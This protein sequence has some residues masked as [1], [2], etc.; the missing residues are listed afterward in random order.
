MRLHS[1]STVRWPSAG[2]VTETLQATRAG[3]GPD[4]LQW[5]TDPSTGKVTMTGPD[6]APEVL[7]IRVTS[8]EVARPGSTYVVDVAGLTV[9]QV[10]GTLS[11]SGQ[12]PERADLTFDYRTPGRGR[13]VASA[14]LVPPYGLTS[15]SDVDEL[16]WEVSAADGRSATA[17][18]DVRLHWAAGTADV[19]VDADRSLLDIGV[20]FGPTGVWRPVLAPVL[21]IYRKRIAAGF[22]TWCA[23]VAESINHGFPEE[24][25]QIRNASDPTEPTRA[26]ADEPVDVA[27]PV[28]VDL[29]PWVDVTWLRS[30]ISVVRHVL[31]QARVPADR[32]VRGRNAS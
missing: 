17:H 4:W 23:S 28:P 15:R 12:E 19:T 5:S 8:G 21:W 27:P 31:A 10:S 32:Q 18:A 9:A 22:E 3:F 11:G 2:L 14:S 29:D 20:D 24:L 30:P 7:P 6:G 13:A 26:P 16:R 25:A 1:Q